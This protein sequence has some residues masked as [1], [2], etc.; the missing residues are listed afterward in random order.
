MELTA[1]MFRREAIQGEWETWPLLTPPDVA[2]EET[3]K[4]ISCQSAGLAVTDALIEVNAEHQ[5]DSFHVSAF[6][7]LLTVAVCI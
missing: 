7:L 1:D 2:G 4:A 3:R 6:A 5:G